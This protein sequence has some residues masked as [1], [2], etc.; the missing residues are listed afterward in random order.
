MTVV[1]V[2][3]EFMPKVGA[4]GTE[5]GSRSHLHMLGEQNL[6]HALA[7]ELRDMVDL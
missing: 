4:S 2:A 5:P 1:V 3:A 6:V 7:P